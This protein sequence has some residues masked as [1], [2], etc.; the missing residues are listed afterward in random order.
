MTHATI[1][2]FKDMK[3]TRTIGGAALKQRKLDHY[4]RRQDGDDSDSESGAD[5][6][7][8][9]IPSKQ[10]R[11]YDRPMSWTR[12]MLVSNSVRSSVGIFDIEEDLKSDKTL[13]QI[14]KAAIREAAVLLFD[15]DHY[16]GAD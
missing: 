7:S 11:L 3:A 1:I 12:V 4:Y 13:K 16:K 10:K 6:V 9:Y 15:P 2:S 14:R 5:D 8:E